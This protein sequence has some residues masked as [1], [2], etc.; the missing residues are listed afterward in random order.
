[1]NLIT[2]T[3][4]KIHL[5]ENWALVTLVFFMVIAGK[6]YNELSNEV[7]GNSNGLSYLI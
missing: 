1:M 4:Y 3:K 5:K 7:G 2:F 6:L